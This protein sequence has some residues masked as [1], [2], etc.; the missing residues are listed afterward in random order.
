MA[1]TVRIKASAL[2]T[3]AKL[4]ASDRARIVT[5]IEALSADPRPQGVTKLAGPEGL[6]RVRSGDHRVIYAVHDEVLL[7]LVVRIGHRRDVYR[8]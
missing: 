6:Y 2:K 4:P 7:V 3:L 8:R 1:Y 5:R